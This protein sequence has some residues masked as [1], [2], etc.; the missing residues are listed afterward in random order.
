MRGSVMVK[1]HGRTIGEVY[2]ELKKALG[3]LVDN[4]FAIAADV[5]KNRWWDSVYLKHVACYA[6]TEE[7]PEWAPA[8]TP[9]AHYVHV[10]MVYKDGVQEPIFIW[11]TDKGLEHAYVVATRCAKELG[12]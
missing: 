6:T 4:R 7:L 2:G 8:D 10:G 11:K 9:R 12:V 1:T 3:D 5:A